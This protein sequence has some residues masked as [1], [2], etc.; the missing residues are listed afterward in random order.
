MTK[1]TNKKGFTIVEV[2]LVLAIAGLIFLMVFIALPSLQKSQRDARRRNDVD[3]VYGALIQYIAN[4]NSLPSINQTQGN[5]DYEHIMKDNIGLN[6][7]KLNE[8]SANSPW[9]KFYWKYLLASGKDNFNDPKTG[10]RYYLNLKG[11]MNKT[12][13]CV[14]FY[15]DDKS[16]IFIFLNAK[17]AHEEPEGSNI[18]Y[19][20]AV[21]N[22]N[23]ITNETIDNDFA[24]AMKL[25]GNGIYCVDNQ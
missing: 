7:E 10:E 18:R 5:S 25:E 19:I 24:V 6:G 11:C 14:N 2:V 12:Q 4:N 17:C 23:T 13:S 9:E 1:P 16:R 22:I 21:K 3:R 8:T 15:N 20:K